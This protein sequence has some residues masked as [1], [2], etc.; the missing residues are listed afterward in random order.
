MFLRL[1]SLTKTSTIFPTSPMEK[2]VESFVV[3]QKVA[4]QADH[5]VQAELKRTPLTC[6][7]LQ[8][9]VVKTV[10]ALLDQK[11]RRIRKWTPE[12][13]ALRCINLANYSHDRAKRENIRD[14]KDPV[15][16]AA[17]HFRTQVFARFFP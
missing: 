15:E 17:S 13:I 10:A 9:E 3:P 14:G 16:Q 7:A 5:L 4:E 1:V 11:S 12:Q 2:T 8:A 6:T